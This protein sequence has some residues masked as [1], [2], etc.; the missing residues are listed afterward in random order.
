MSDM[1]SKVDLVTPTLE[2]LVLRDRSLAVY[3]DDTGHESLKGQPVYGLGGC[4]NLGRDYERIIN[5]PW[6]AVRKH[7]AGSPTRRSRAAHVDDASTGATKFAQ[8]LLIV[9][10]LTGSLLA[11]SF[12]AQAVQDL[13]T[14]G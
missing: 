2:R 5:Q 4:A 9:L 10:A 7:V 12:V 13:S 6:R 1:I 11:F 8:A 14:I 3:V